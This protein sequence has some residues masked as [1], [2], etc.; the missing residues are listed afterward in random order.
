MVAMRLLDPHFS[1]RRWLK[2]GLTVSGAVAGAAFGLALTRLGKIVA[3]APPATLANYAWNAAVF[4]VL[5]GI[6]SPVVSWSVLRRVPLW[7]TIIEPLAFAAAGGTVAVILGA[8]ILL[9]MLPPAGLAFG[10]LQLQRRYP[11]PHALPS[12]PPANER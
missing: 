5:A 11:D 1:T 8:P 6:V 12:T 7:R 3:G 4:G 10:F 2:V 9:L